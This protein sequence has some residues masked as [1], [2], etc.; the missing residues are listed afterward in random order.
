MRDM[1]CDKMLIITNVSLAT[2]SLSQPN[3]ISFSFCSLA[4]NNSLPQFIPWSKNYLITE[5]HIV[6]TIELFP[7]FKKFPWEAQ[8]LKKI[9]T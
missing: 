5:F 9:I 6:S 8:G 2:C 3:I 7:S 4:L 1:N